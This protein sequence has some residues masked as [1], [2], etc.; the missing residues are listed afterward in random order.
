MAAEGR[1]HEISERES[2]E[3]TVAGSAADA[4]VAGAAVVIAIRGLLGASPVTAAACTTVAIGAGL[5]FEGGAI[6][7]RFRRSLRRNE[8][9][10]LTRGDVL[11]G[12]TADAVAGLAGIGLGVLALL[13]VA[14]WPLLGT[15][16]LVYG[17][18]LLLGCAALVH[19]TVTV[20]DGVPIPPTGTDVALLAAGGQLVIGLLALALASLA[21]LGTASQ[22]LTLVALLAVA[23]SELASGLALGTKMLRMRKMLRATVQ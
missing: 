12:M 14:P 11:G 23:A 22:V 15:A 18:A 16:V 13:D 7:A 20:R 10:S 3:L 19:A 17:A 8:E 2:V 4:L 5:L 9:D 6:F 1:S 21:L